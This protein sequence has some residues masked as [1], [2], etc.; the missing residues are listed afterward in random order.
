MTDLRHGYTLSDV[1]QM[2]S[3]AVKADRSMAM[4][5]ADRRDIAWFAIVEALYAADTPTGRQDLIRTGWQ[6]I[7]REVRDGYRQ[8]GYR[9]RAWDAGYATA[10][11]FVTYWLPMQTVPSHEDR[12]VDRVALP[13]ILAALTDRQREV[14]ATVAAWD[15]DRVQ[16]AGAL[17]IDE[18]ALNHQ[19][20]MG[21]RACLALWLEGETPQQVSLRRL[22]RRR[23]RGEVA[24]CGTV[25]G[26]F[27]HRDRRETLDGACMAAEREHDRAR[28][29]KAGGSRG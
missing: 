22:D 9:D 14:L 29:A 26:A 4:D 10:P 11:R 15:G 13:R 23:H 18:K 7:Y 16:S 21:R 17:G 12:I 20:R 25:A 24:P 2:T 27:R 5:Y 6:A 1:H 3:A 19:L 28:K 8:Y